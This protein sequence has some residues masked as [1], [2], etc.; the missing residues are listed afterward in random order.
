MLLQGASVEML[1]PVAQFVAQQQT[2]PPDFDPLSNEQRFVVSRAVMGVIRAAVLEEQPFFK[3]QSFEDELV[4]LVLAY[5][6]A[7]QSGAAPG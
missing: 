1:A 2:S 6:I 4:R 5:A 3:R 7:T